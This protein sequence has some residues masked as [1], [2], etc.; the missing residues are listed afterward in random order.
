VGACFRWLSAIVILLLIAR[1]ESADPTTQGAIRATHELLGDDLRVEVRELDAPPSDD[2][3]LE[4][5]AQMGAG[6]VIEL[7]WESRNHAQARVH[8]HVEPRPGWNDRVIGF[9]ESDD[10]WERGR[11]VGFAI[12]SMLPAPLPTPAGETPLAVR[13]P[14]PQGAE[15]GVLVAAGPE[16]HR[17]GSVD[18]MGAV[19]LGVGGESPGWGGA[20]SARWYFGYP[21]GFRLGLSARAGEIDPAQATTLQM[22]LAAGLVWL[23]L[24]ATRQRR[25]ELGVRVDALAMRERLTHF[26][27]DD[28]EPVDLARWLPGADA[29]IEASWLFNPSAGL[30]ASFA[31]EVAFG[32]T[33]VTLHYERVATVPP[34]RLVFQ[35]GVRASF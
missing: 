34:F 12:A 3:A 29:A 2:R 10:F 11:T 25:F 35:T 18:A 21:F 13:L 9:M 20:A 4:L 23:P 33:D 14:A 19:A 32:K 6:A 30:I 8:F 16:H 17:V 26:D 1:G 31:G 7:S 24:A 5:G 22:H 15:T 28:T 27:S